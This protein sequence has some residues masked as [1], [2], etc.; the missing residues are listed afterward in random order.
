M[1]CVVGKGN[2]MSV[3]SRT[4]ELTRELTNNP[5][6]PLLFI[7]EATK[8]SAFYLVGE[9]SGSVVAVS[10]VMAILSIL[11]WLYTYDEVKWGLSKASEVAEDV[12]ED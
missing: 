5:F 7:G 3:S 6:F 9:A 8:T 11:G 10:T 1:S 12:T 2:R 4:K